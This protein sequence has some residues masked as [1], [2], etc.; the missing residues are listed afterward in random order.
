MIQKQD[1][2]SVLGLGKSGAAAAK[3]L[4]KLGAK[5]EVF[6]QKKE[7]SE[8]PEAIEL[9]EQ[10]IAVHFQPS[11]DQIVPDQLDWLVKNPGVPYSNPAVQRAIEKSVPVITEVEL[12]A[13][14]L[15]VPIIGITGSNGKTTTTT[16][17]GEMLA[18]SSI[19]TLVAGNIGRA[20]SDVVEEVTTE[21]WIV[22]ELSSF[23]LK[24]T[25]TFHPHIAA[26][27]N[28]VPAHLDYHQSL[29]DYVK[30][31]AKLFQNLNE[32]DIAVF[33]FD[34]ELCQKVAAS[35]KGTIYWFSIEQGV[36]KGLFVR[37]GLMIA[38]IDDEEQVIMPVA[39]IALPGDRNLENAL[40][41]SAIA[42]AAGG[43][44]EAIRSVLQSFTGVEHR[45]E[46]VS[47]K[48]HV[49]YYNDSKATNAQAAITALTA[50][51]KPLIWIGG[52]LDRG[53]DF[54]ELIPYLRKHVKAAIVYG[55]TASILADRA[56]D[57]GISAIIHADDVEDAVHQ[58]SRIAVK[59]DIVVLSPACASWDQY[60]SFEVRGRIF[61]Q[62]VHTL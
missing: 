24:G 41:A 3:L 62:A 53:V 30:S 4:A 12:A 18:K 36:E 37:D 7:R 56:K 33:N 17:V 19:P 54:Q 34:H 45:L 39:E 52:G 1:H 59:G 23:Q 21:K 14:V 49:R 50:F 57:A 8:S 60:P 25:N 29:D 16:I 40:A 10:G 32:D 13:S 48:D 6:E 51:S 42:L 26:L 44:K 46:Y 58:A 15:E 27:L 20:L 28:I 55:E 31:K 38:R 2:V 35:Q 22:A 11:N 47:I 61:K 5:V 9:E 43:K